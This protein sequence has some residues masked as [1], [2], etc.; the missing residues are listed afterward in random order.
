MT[1]IRFWVSARAEHSQVPLEM[2]LLGPPPY[3][4]SRLS[5]SKEQPSPTL[6]LLR[7]GVPNVFPSLLNS[8]SARSFLIPTNYPQSPVIIY[9]K[10]AYPVS[11]RIQAIDQTRSGCQ[12]LR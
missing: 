5:A 2:Y 1:R 12:W 4:D 11:S 9:S 10:N 3:L 7:L 8:A 6:T